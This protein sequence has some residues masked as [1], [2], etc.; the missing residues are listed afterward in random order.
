MKVFPLVAASATVLALTVSIANADIVLVRHAEK[1]SGENPVL[2]ECGS[3]RARNLAKLL[4]RFDFSLALSTDYRRTRQTAE[5]IVKHM[6]VPIEMYDAGDLVS[7]AERL[8]VAKERDVLVVGHSN[9]TPELAELLTGESLAWFDH[10]DYDQLLIVRS[11]GTLERQQ[12]LFRC[13]TSVGGSTEE[14][15][16]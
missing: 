14:Q 1:A 3:A 7:L 4:D 2:T 5:E 12:Q 15:S 6:D 13:S 11:N 16:D 9:T 10:D 8:N